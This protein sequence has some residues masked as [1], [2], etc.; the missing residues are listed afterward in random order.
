[1]KHRA[2]AVNGPLAGDLNLTVDRRDDGGWPQEVEWTIPAGR[3]R[4]RFTE[5]VSIG[6]DG[7]QPMYEQLVAETEPTP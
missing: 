3:V 2:I 5:K 6:S 1:M 7:G 4:Y